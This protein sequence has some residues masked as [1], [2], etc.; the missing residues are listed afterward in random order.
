MII[1]QRGRSFQVCISRNKRRWRKQFTTREAAEVWGAQAWADVRAGRE[2]NMGGTERIPNN[3]PKTLGALID[4]TYRTHWEG[5]KSGDDSRNNAEACAEV[6]GFDRDV[7]KIDMFDIDNLIQ[8]FKDLHR[9]NGTINRKTAALS[10]CLAIA[11]DLG[12]ILSKP[13][14]RKL[15]EKQGRIRWFTD[16]ELFRMETYFHHI[17][18][19]EFAHWIRFQADTGLRCGETRKLLW[20]DV[21]GDFV[22]VIDSKSGR[23]RGVP[24]T[25]AARRAVEFMRDNKKGPFTWA[26]QRRIR[27]RWE[28]LRLHMG[29]EIGDENV[30][31][32]LRHTFVSRLVQRGKQFHDIATLAGHESIQTTRRYAHL[33]PHNLIDTISVLE[34]NQ[35]PSLRLTS[36]A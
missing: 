10:K 9:S 35:Q 5:Q 26:T 13:K 18:R 7:R 20:E 32:T 22:V 15:A 2:P 3:M 24:M 31:H 25:T 23:D 19:P 8:H 27:D 29:W 4:Y 14:I 6:L 21:S 12:L 11:K 33:A 16:E 30:P 34:P 28:S 17:E 1:R 36:V